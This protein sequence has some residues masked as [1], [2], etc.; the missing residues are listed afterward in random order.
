MSDTSLVKPGRSRIL[1]LPLSLITYGLALLALLIPILAPLSSPS[2]QV[3]QVASQDIRAAQAISYESEVLTEQQREAAERAIP[4]QYTPP[5]TGVARRQLETLRAVLAY[6]SSVRADNFAS[7]EQK[8]A[9][10][11]ALEEIH[12]SQDT[13]ARLLALSE[14][15]WQSVQQEAIVVLEQ[16]MRSTIREDRL[17]EARRSVP[18]LVS[19]SLPEEQAAIVAELAAALVAPNSF[20]SEELTEAA[21]QKAGEAVAPVTRSF[22]AGETVIQRGQVLTAANLEA[23]QKLG[24]VQ[25]QFSWKDLLGAAIIALLAVGIMLNYL[26]RTLFL[27]QG[28]RA[29]ALIVVLFSAFMLVARLI[30]PAQTV[31]PYLFPL[32]AYGLIVAA[33]FGAEPALITA[34]MLAILAAYHLPNAIELTIFYILSGFFGVLALGRAQRMISFFWAGVAVAGSGMLVILTYRLPQPNIDW[35]GIATLSGAAFLNGIASASLTLLLQL[36]LAQFLGMT[37]ALQLMEISRPDHPLLQLLLRNAP[38]T[39]QHSLQVANL[40]EQ[41]AE[42]IGADTLLTRVGALYHD[43]GKALNPAFYIENQVP[44]SVNPHEGLDPLTS[45]QTIIRH[46]ADGVE[47]ARKYRLPKR[48]QNFIREHHGTMIT[49]YQYYNALQAAGGNEDQVN[50]EDFRY[51]GPRPQSRETAVLM[52]ADGSEARMRAERPKDETELRLLIKAVIDHRVSTA[53]LDQTDLTLRDLDEIVDSFATTLRGIYHPRIEYPMLE[54]ANL[55][56]SDTSP[57]IPAMLR[58]STELPVHSPTE[59]PPGAAKSP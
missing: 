58:S 25:P 16:V 23:L 28:M 18:A 49:R 27:A 17:E 7:P 9:D 37:T 48:V 22:K 11:S 32:S 29:L 1:F 6:I 53:Q 20:F 54:K 40:A 3:G 26:W 57:T 35:I 50:E 55:P 42:R 51:P 45:A 12:I 33:L 46:I 43:V 8:L 15:R 4:N 2:L 38:G 21:R 44:G 36:F 52:L 19:L 56:R 31:I 10:L 59:S 13:A 39:Y 24:L 14:S 5:D 47:L 41:A 34:L 30:I